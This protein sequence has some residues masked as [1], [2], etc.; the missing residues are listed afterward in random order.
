MKAAPATL[1]VSG[2]EQVTLIQ[3]G[4]EEA[5]LM[6]EAQRETVKVQNAETLGSSLCQCAGR[7]REK[8]GL[9]TRLPTWDGAGLWRSSL[10]QWLHLRPA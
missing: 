5:V 9:G 6:D 10:P 8:V 1:H 2:A 4:T 7:Q 3:V